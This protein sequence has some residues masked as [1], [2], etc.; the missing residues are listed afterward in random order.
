MSDS[1]RPH[2]SQHARPPC[3]SPTP[4]L[5]SDSLPSSHEE[6]TVEPDTTLTVTKTT[7]SEPENGEAYGLG[8]VISY[9]ITV[10]ND[11][12]VPYKNV[13]VTDELTGLSETIAELAVG[14]SE[15]ITT[16]YTVTSEDILAGSVLNEAT[17]KADPID[18][19]DP[20]SPEPEGGDT[21]ETPID[22]NVVLTILYF[23]DDEPAEDMT[24]TA[25]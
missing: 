8:E 21:E 19:D 9:E 12:N 23:I 14:A 25:T 3:P 24:F 17:A 16:E 13:V 2:E 4:R 22:Q 11:G 1:L 20:D 18:P 6:P 5:H 15:T 10:T 7:T